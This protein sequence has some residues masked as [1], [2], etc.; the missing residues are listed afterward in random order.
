LVF[1]VLLIALGNLCLGFAIAVRTRRSAPSDACSTAVAA[2]PRVDS[3]A[4]TASSS[5]PAESEIDLSAVAP[6]VE[7]TPKPEPAPPRA[8]SET[9]AT[10]AEVMAGLQQF[11]AQISKLDT[12]VR[13]C[14]KS[15]D[16]R[17]I[18][19]CVQELHEANSQFIESTQVAAAQLESRS[20]H[21]NPL[22]A[23]QTKLQSA[24][25]EQVKNVESVNKRVGSLHTGNDPD[26]SCE[27]LLAE[28]NTLAAANDSLQGG[29]EEIRVE[30][31]QAEGWFDQVDEADS[32]DPT[33]GVAGRGAFQRRLAALWKQDDNQATV[34]MIG[35]DHAKRI[36]QDQGAEVHDRVLRGVA[37]RMRSS[38]QESA[39]VA[40]Y[41]EQ[42]FLLLL[43][44]VAPRAAVTAVETVRQTVEATAFA[45]G[46][47]E[48]E[49]TV[50]CA[51]TQTDDQDTSESLFE[52]LKNTLQEA[53][54]YGRNRTFLHEGKYPAPVVPPNLSIEAPPYPLDETTSP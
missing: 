44:G 25:A 46:D 21:L 10:V 4:P 54:R 11:R 31:A 18:E 23:V 17:Q 13:Q 37:D 40:Y 51:V 6:D 2:A 7:L 52:R 9:E 43:E 28:T 15:R 8:K 50:S 29:L 19:G 49:V 41:G 16:S 3:P 38:G 33:T 42:K 14:A 45:L 12:K 53:R 26:G 22:D 27:Q 1:Y 35:L 39:W 36:A 47:E 30:V 5:A 34:A 48:L 32:L 20:D 24:L